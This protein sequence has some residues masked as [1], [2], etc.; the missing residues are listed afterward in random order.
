MTHLTLLLLFR[1]TQWI[2]TIWINWQFTKSCSPSHMLHLRSDVLVFHLPCK[3]EH[4]VILCM[5]WQKT[6]KSLFFCGLQI[7]LFLV[8]SIFCWVWNTSSL[9]LCIFIM[10]ISA[11]PPPSSLFWTGNCSCCGT[12]ITVILS[13]VVTG[14]TFSVLYIWCWLVWF[15]STAFQFRVH[16]KWLWGRPECSWGEE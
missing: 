8:S 7:V 4:E 9:L 10:L 12:S 2:S 15:T 14:W 6:Y 5:E 13:P 1:Y 11:D 16:S 3:Y